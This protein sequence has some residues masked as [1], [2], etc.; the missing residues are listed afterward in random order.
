MSWPTH[1]LPSMQLISYYNYT[2]L[3]DWLSRA[4]STSMAVAGGF[5][6]GCDEA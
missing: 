6:M 3:E 5:G 1:A 2:T 4:T